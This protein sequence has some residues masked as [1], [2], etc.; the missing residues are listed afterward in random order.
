M[1]TQVFIV[2]HVHEFSDGH[3]DTKLIGVYTSENAAHEAVERLRSVEG[4]RDNPQGFTV[5][6]Y[7]VDRDN[8]TEG[9]VTIEAD[10]SSH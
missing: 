6:R 2:H 3:E 8:W 5:D 9:F 1:L 4:F 10:A 7:T